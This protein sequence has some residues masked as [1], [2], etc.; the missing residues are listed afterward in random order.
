MPIE[1]P[2]RDYTWQVITAR[3]PAGPVVFY[4][5]DDA[6]RDKLISKLTA[7]SYAPPVDTGEPGQIT[8]A[9]GQRV[10]VSAY[11]RDRRGVVKR[12]GPRRVVVTFE[13][14]RAGGLATRPFSA[15]EI[16]PGS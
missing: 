15:F 10:T 7:S 12:L 4:A 8:L 5:W 13:R 1:P 11:G 2:S 3:Y 6:E 16:K 9:V 14:N